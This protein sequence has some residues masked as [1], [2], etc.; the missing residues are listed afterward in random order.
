MRIALLVAGLASGCAKQENNIG[1]EARHP[2]MNR[3]ST[4]MAVGVTFAHVRTESH[5]LSWLLGPRSVIERGFEIQTYDLKNRRGPHRIAR[6][7]RLP[8]E[9]PWLI[10][11][12]DS[13]I[14]VARGLQDRMRTERVDP[15]TGDTMT[16]AHQGSL[17]EWSDALN[18]FG[19]GWDPMRRTHVLGGE[20]GF[21]L[22]NPRTRQKE[23]LFALPPE[24]EGHP[25]PMAPWRVESAARERDSDM[26]HGIWAVLT[27]PGA[28]STRFLIETY[29]P[30]PG[31][32][33][34]SYVLTLSIDMPD[35]T[36]SFSDPT[37]PLERRV[38]RLGP[39]ATKLQLAVSTRR[40]QKMLD[41][42]RRRVQMR[43]PTWSAPV[44]VDLRR[45]PEHEASSQRFGPVPEAIA[46]IG[47]TEVLIPIH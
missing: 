45:V 37:L 30:R 14:L 17:G 3:D 15:L 32:E 11:W 28:D 33:T 4:W 39:T 16:I 6:W 40:L 2:V 18:D 10:G 23:F 43:P 41:P 21:F 26:I 42:Y 12:D 13:G 25:D 29:V 46:G 44:F 19:S 9:S 1:A 8:R 38:F 5:I 22:W 47:V 35:T 27:R 36:G 24:H 31:A 34:R 7:P 20:A